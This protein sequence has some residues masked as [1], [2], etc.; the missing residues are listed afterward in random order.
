[1]NGPAFWQF[2]FLLN[3]LILFVISGLNFIPAAQA[4]LLNHFHKEHDQ[5]VDQSEA[6]MHW[7]Q[8]KDS[9]ASYLSDDQSLVVLGPVEDHE[10]NV[11]QEGIDR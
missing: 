1:M 10:A 11:E 3:L 5:L 9:Q 4:Q 6:V 2:R 8:G 7:T